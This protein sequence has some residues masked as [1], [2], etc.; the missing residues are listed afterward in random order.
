[1]VASIRPSETPEGKLWLEN[2]GARSLHAPLLLL[3]SLRIVSDATIR[4]SLISL[5]TRLVEES[6]PPIALLP[7]REVHDRRPYYEPGEA[8]SLP[9][10]FRASALPGSEA[11]VANAIRDI[12]NN[13]GLRNRLIGE[14]TLG[15]LRRERCRTLLLVDDY[16]G[17]GNRATKFAT[18]LLR[19]PSIRSWRSYGLIRLQVALFAASP[20]AMQTITSSKRVD[21]LS[22]ITHG[23]DFR[24]AR[25]SDDELREVRELCYSFARNKEWALGYSGSEGLLVMQHTVPNNLPAILWQSKGPGRRKWKPFFAGRTMTP[26]QQ[27]VLGDYSPSYT[28]SQIA[29]GFRQFRLARRLSADSDQTVQTLLLI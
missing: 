18:A 9:E 26:R 17:S 29:E 12:V 15:A 8:E 23:G 7:I 25:W 3:D 20:L 16:A 27:L 14:P 10:Y 21:E 28:A 1:M 4:A 19:T 11:L 5:V 2:F 6:E 13:R 24:S 22:V